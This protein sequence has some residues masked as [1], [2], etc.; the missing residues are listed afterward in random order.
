MRA[1]TKQ[2]LQ[3]IIDSDEQWEKAK[4]EVTQI[5][6]KHSVARA[7]LQEQKKLTFQQEQKARVRTN[8]ACVQRTWSLTF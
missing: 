8:T 1:E 6:A 3:K 2:M 4:E 5:V 7:K